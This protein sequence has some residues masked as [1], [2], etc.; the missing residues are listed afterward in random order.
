MPGRFSQDFISKV[1]DATNILDIV[2]KQTRLTKKGGRYFGVCPFHSEKTPSFSV[3]PDKNLYYCFGCGAGGNVIGFV[4]EVYK[5]SFPEAIEYLAGLANIP[6]EYESGGISNDSYQKKKR[7]MQI[8]RDAAKFFYGMLLKNPRAMEYVKK[9]GLSDETMQTFGIGWAPGNNTLY[10]YLKQKGYSDAEL[11]ETSLVR[12]HNGRHYDYFKNR[13]MFPIMDISDNI[14]AFGGRVLDNTQPKYLNSPETPVF[15]KH[16]M[17]YNLNRAKKE[18]PQEPLV[19]AEGYMD[20]ISLWDKGIKNVCATLGTALGEAHAKL[21]QRY[22]DNVVLCYDGDAPGRSAAVR[23]SDILLKAGLEP[24]VLL[25]EG[26]EDPDSYVRKFGADAFREKVK[27]CAYATDFKIN[28]LRSKYDTDDIVQ[29]ARFLKEACAA[30]AETNDE[31]KWDYYVKML[32]GMTDTDPGVIKN[33]LFKHAD[34]TPVQSAPKEEQEQGKTRSSGIDLAQKR[35]LN[36]IL[37]DYDAYRAFRAFGG[38]ASVFMNESY[39]GIYTEIERA[40]TDENIVD[41]TQSL[42]YNNKIAQVIATINAEDDPIDET[43]VKEYIIA[44]QAREIEEEC[45]RIKR[46][47][48]DI[49]QSNSND[50]ELLLKEY[51]YLKRKLLELKSGG[52]LDD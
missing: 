40:Y 24:K 32:A 48:S 38:T 26:N 4:M 45:K 11:L 7:M 5:Y 15:Y 2:S 39:R 17:L 14:V 28:E 42:L 21:I 25:L 43:E 19:I 13:V 20:V 30:V 35:L 31:I 3:N 37:S 18:L 36:Y 9:R 52:D 16:N 22:T 1:L 46:R 41:I 12:E 44:L 27:Q 47:I 50:A 33:Q 34:S 51:N 8:N 23:G 6:L 49:G 29:R 10:A